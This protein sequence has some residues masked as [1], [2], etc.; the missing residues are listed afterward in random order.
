MQIFFRSAEC[1]DDGVAQ[2]DTIASE[3]KAGEILEL[4]GA[5]RSIHTSCVG[6]EIAKDFFKVI[7]ISLLSFPARAVRRTHTFTIKIL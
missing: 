1:L 5:D 6:P 3:T 2:K 7:H 4:K